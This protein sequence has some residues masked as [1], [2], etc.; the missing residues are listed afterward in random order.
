MSGAEFDK[1][2]K[3]I[4]NYGLTN[5]QYITRPW[6]HFVAETL[7]NPETGRFYSEDP[8]DEAKSKEIVKKAI[9]SMQGEED[10]LFKTHKMQL[11]YEANCLQ[12]ENQLTEELRIST[13]DSTKLIDNILEVKAG[14]SNNYDSLSLLY[15]KI[16]AFLL[17]KNKQLAKNKGDY[18]SGYEAINREVN[19]A[20]ESVIP[21]PALSPF[22]MLTNPEKAAQI[23]ELNHLV[24]G[25]RLFNKEIGKGGASLDDVAS[26]SN[27]L[28]QNFVEQM[29]EKLTEVGSEIENYSNYLGYVSDNGVNDP[30]FEQLK[31]ELI[32]LRQFTSYATTLYDKTENSVS[33]ID[34]S[35]S[36]YEKEISDLRKLLANSSSAP[37]DTVYPKFATLANTYI[38]LLEESKSAEAKKKL[39]ETLLEC[40][41]SVALSLTEAQIHTAQRY[42]ASASRKDEEKPVRYENKNL[43]YFIEPRNTPEFLQ[44]P[45]D[46][47]GFSIVSLVD[48][49]GLLLNGK[50][51]LGVFKYEDYMLV[52]HS[53]KEI[54]K[55]IERP[56]FY[57]EKFYQMCR[58]YPAL[59][60]LL[61][62]EGYFKERN[63]KLLDFHED[64]RDATRTLCD[65][66]IE[67]EL[68][69]QPNNF[70]HNYFWNEWD[71][72]RRAIQMANIRNMA[73]KASQTSDS[74]FK[75]ENETQVWLKK[76]AATMTG[77]ENGTNPIR[78]RNYITELRE[79]TAN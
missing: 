58:K 74:I 7:Y 62:L 73:T 46:L 25:I 40:Y 22:I 45:L 26:L 30:S 54:R 2:V 64:F 48:Q 51:N 29:R 78:P 43:V 65:K 77:I 27:R 72:R 68:H 71:M 32:F 63:I 56:Q 12:I 60:I 57:F 13:S 52:F 17:F 47:A 15:Q 3:E 79:K 14:G 9:A 75:V 33:I 19:A 67:T 38:S 5:R 55:F 8:I 31:K 23:S 53:H 34:V 70:D 66:T 16:Y 76:E 42:A 20:L 36:R 10:V 21:R 41:K 11:K 59:I 39:F 37:K 69:P 4:V 50:H 44:T 24:L 6:A 61:G 28:D 35:K 18:Q 1:I 49:D